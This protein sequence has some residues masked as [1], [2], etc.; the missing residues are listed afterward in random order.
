[1]YQQLFCLLT[2]KTLY[3]NDFA[4]LLIKKRLYMA[5]HTHTLDYNKNE[6]YF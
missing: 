2:Y 6:C 1:M 3:P 5:T 4:N